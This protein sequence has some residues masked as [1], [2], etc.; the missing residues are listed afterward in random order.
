MF[1]LLSYSFSSSP[2]L[3]DRDVVNGDVVDERGTVSLEAIFYCP[4]WLLERRLS[5]VDADVTGL[6]VYELDGGGDGSFLCT[7]KGSSW[8]DATR[9][10]CGLL[11]SNTA[12][13]SVA[14]L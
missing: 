6:L 3:A 10:D 13:R 1:V 4:G 12:G 8:V 9:W 7:L 2:G 5:T 11:L 14:S